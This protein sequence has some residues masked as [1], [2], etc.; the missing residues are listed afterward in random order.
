MSTTTEP[1]FA[2]KHT[3]VIALGLAVD[4]TENKLY[5]GSMA[6][7][8]ISC[9]SLWASLVA[10]KAKNTYVVGWH[11][12]NFNGQ[13]PIKTVNQALPGSSFTHLICVSRVD[14][15]ILAIEPAAGGLTVAAER[16]ALLTN[17][18]PTI[19]T[20]FTSLLNTQ[21]NVPVLPTWAE[22]LWTTAQT[23]PG[24]ITT[25]DSYGDCLGAWLIDLKFDWLGLVSEL[26]ASRQLTLN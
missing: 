20:H 13:P 1:K 9:K 5:Y 25:L 6:G 8:A 12:D 10:D 22:I 18:I 3:K 2:N 11:Y 19:L 26:L 17:H 23:R 7:P 14:N 24:A 16:K 21:T 15:L 4:S